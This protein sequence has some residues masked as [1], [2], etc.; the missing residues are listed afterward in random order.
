M[1][2]KGKKRGVKNPALAAGFLNPPQI[3]DLDRGGLIL[4]ELSNCKTTIAKFFEAFTQHEAKLSPPCTRKVVMGLSHGDLHG[5]NL[6]L[7][8]QGL[9][10][11]IDFATVEDDTH[12][13]KD[14]T[15]FLA[16]CFFL[17]LHESVNED[18]INRWAK[19]FATTPDATTALPLL[20]EANVEK[21]DQEKA[22]FLLSLLGRLR[23]CMCLYEI[24]D[25]APNN[26]GLPFA[27]ALFSWSVRMLS[28]SEPTHY[29]KKRAVYFAVATAQRLMMEAKIDVGK[30]GTEWIND[31]KSVWEGQ[32]GRRLST[33]ATQLQKLKFDFDLEF[34]RYLSQVGATEAWTTDLLT[35]GE[36]PCDG[37]RNNSLSEVFRE[38]G[39][40]AHDPFSTGIKD[41][42]QT[43]LHSFSFVAR[44]ETSRAILRQ[45]DRHWRFRHRQDYLDQTVF[46]RSVATS[47]Q[48]RRGG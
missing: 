3:D 10:W 13:L 26:D 11:L 47:T 27:V 21:Q 19:L 43:C 1:L 30:K 42:E 17:Y 9:V 31:F 20:S 48:R 46:F 29:Q 38:S 44:S 34:P 18:S 25:D 4:S 35:R 14:L 16:S 24:G 40:K 45:V 22:F 33:S 15:K 5:G 28:Y 36:S 8:S 12:V 32:K 41:L 7:D 23:H 2:P 39:W 37:K 6:L